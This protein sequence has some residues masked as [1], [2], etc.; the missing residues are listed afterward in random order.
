MRILAL[1]AAALL[2]SATAALAAPVSV[3]VA[4]APE[5]QKTFEKTYGVRE[6][7]R[8]TADL[9]S[10]VEKTLARS[11]AHDGARIELVLTDVKPNRP[12]F[13][14]LSDTP[15]LSMQSFGIGG[16]AIKGRI[17]AA[18]G[19]EKPLSYRWYESDIRQASYNWIWSD[20]EWTFD[21]FAR[22]LVRDAEIAQR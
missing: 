22:K 6:A 10:S 15:G 19:S 20:A 2:A 5:L 4:V 3:T 13:K 11:G 8:L 16:A 14:Q 17:V 21:R 12:T 1:S 18:D 7:E 9:Q